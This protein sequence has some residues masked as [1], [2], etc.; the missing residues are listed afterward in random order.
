MNQISSLSAGSIATPAAT[1]IADNDNN[2]VARARGLQ[3]SVS[4]VSVSE[5][6]I[7]KDEEY[8]EI[9]ICCESLHLFINRA[10]DEYNN[11]GNGNSNSN[12]NSKTMESSQSP[13]ASP[14]PISAGLIR[15]LSALNELKMRAFKHWSQKMSRELFQDF[16]IQLENKCMFWGIYES[17]YTKTIWRSIVI[18]N[19][20][21]DEADEQH[22][23]Q[24][25]QEQ[26]HEDID[27]DADAESEQEMKIFLPCKPSEYI[28]NVCFHFIRILLMIITQQNVVQYFH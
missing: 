10:I 1:A 24:Q 5:Q 21:D 12:S 3:R 7:A 11:N 26:Q 8:L 22:E 20:K 28:H 16:R 25:E 27:A 19:S 9:G 17:Y 6:P 13:I 23:Q 18:V 14:T 15:I 2:H 4:S